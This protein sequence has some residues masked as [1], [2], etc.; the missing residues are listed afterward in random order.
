MTKHHFL[1]QH[2]FLS[3]L[4]NIHSTKSTKLKLKV[5]MDGDADADADDALLSGSPVIRVHAPPRQ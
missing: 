3:E 4:A 2:R 1:S 5:L